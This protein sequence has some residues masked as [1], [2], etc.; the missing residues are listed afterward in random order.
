MRHFSILLAV[1]LLLGG[2]SSTQHPAQ[3]GYDIVLGEGARFEPGKAGYDP[4][5][6]GYW[7]NGNA[8]SVRLDPTVLAGRSELVLSVRTAISTPRLSL[9]RVATPGH[10]VTVRSQDKNISVSPF[11]NPAHV[12]IL[13]DTGYIRLEPSAERIKVILSAA[14]LQE[15]APHGLSVF[16]TE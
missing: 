1:A 8:T 12:E 4:S 16:W 13:R 15:Y 11:D 9:L 5:L 7:V 14:F 2:C 10:I 3:P 6:G